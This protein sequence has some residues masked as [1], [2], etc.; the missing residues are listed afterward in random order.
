MRYD[1]ET[2]IRHNRNRRNRQLRRHIRILLLTVVAVLGISFGMFSIHAK[3][4]SHD[5]V[6]VYKYYKSVTVHGN[7]TLWNYAMK[8]APDDDYDKYI[9]EV[10]RMNNLRDDNIDVS[11][12][13]IIPYYSNE[14]VD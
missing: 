3:A 5:S 13:I 8:Y 14:F 10:V 12:N 7:D 6:H 11:M 4:D 9:R 1:Y 2:V